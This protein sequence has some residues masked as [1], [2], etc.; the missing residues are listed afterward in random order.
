VE[1][2]VAALVGPDE[3]AAAAGRSA[4]DAVRGYFLDKTTAQKIVVDWRDA[5]PGDKQYHWEQRGVPLRIE[6]GPRDVAAGAVVLKR[7]FD[8]EKSTVALADLSPQWLRQKM[9]QIHAAMLDKARTFR[10]QNTREAQSYDQMKQILAEQGGFVR[11]WFKPDRT[12]E[13]KIKEQTKATVR[14]ILL[15]RQ[16][17][18]AAG[19]PCIFSGQPTQTRVLFAQAY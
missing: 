9:D 17:G 3:L 18:G 15:D 8:R 16:A 19:G 11:A 14:C 4:S 13:A 12:A 5:R 2:V 1:K 10:D 6:I 7:R